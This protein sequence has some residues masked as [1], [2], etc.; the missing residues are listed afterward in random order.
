M[1]ENVMKPFSNR[2]YGRTAPGQHY[3][4]RLENDL[5]EF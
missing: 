5:E 1:Q 3:I 4:C 2:A